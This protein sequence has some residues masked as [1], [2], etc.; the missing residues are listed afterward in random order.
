ME[1]LGLGWRRYQART[2][3]VTR[4]WAFHDQQNAQQHT[5]L[6][7]NVPAQSARK[8]T[9]AAGLVSAARKA[10]TRLGP[11]SLSLAQRCGEW[12]PVR[13]Q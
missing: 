1:S 3:R 8:T 5:H 10:A 6:W 13:A 9:W 7:F 4:A 2:R 11:R 12:K